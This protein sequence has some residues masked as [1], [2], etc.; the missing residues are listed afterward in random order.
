MAYVSNRTLREAFERSGLTAG[1]LG[2][3]LGYEESAREADHRVRR[4]LGCKP[5]RARGRAY[6]NGQTR[7]QEA[8]A[9]RYAIALNLDPSEIGL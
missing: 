9:L 7:M 6:P 1:Q 8:T 4:A 5:Y 2:L 3:L